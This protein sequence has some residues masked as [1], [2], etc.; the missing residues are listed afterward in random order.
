MAALRKRSFEEEWPDL[1]RK[2]QS[3]LSAKRVPASKREDIVQETGLR[4]FR[5]WE[6]VDPERP[7]WAL[8]VTIALNLVRDEARRSSTRE[9]LGAVPDIP[10]SYDVERSG[11][12]RIELARV[13][14]ALT[15]MTPA[16]RSVLLAEVGD[17]AAL[18]RGANAV[19]MLR[20]RARRRLTSL[21]DSASAG[22]VLAGVKLRRLFRWGDGPMSLRSPSEGQDLAH[23]V[24]GIAA[25]VAMFSLIPGGFDRPS[26]PS[27]VGRERAH[28]ALTMPDLAGST[29]QLDPELVVG[30]GTDRLVDNPRLRE[31][32]GRLVDKPRHVRIGMGSD[33]VEGTARVAVLGMEARVQDRAEEPPV[34][35]SGLP[36]ES[37]SSLECEGAENTANN[38]GPAG[39]SVEARVKLG[40]FRATVTVDV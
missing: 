16:H 6:Q 36:V 20:M 26:G 25:A 14:H 10:S 9:I 4:L 38:D 34:C 29:A 5:M 13:E 3:L 30:P 1:A 15:Q 32:A 7:V 2:L 23:A 33:Y 27:D 24:A 19:K 28:L 35:A 22:G 8:T 12:A 11:L 21:L 18:T 40:R 17:E 39:G 37:P 31:R